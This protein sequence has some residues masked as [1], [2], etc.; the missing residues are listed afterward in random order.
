MVGASAVTTSMTGVAK[1]WSMP[2]LRRHQGP[3]GSA[4]SRPLQQP[5][6][7]SRTVHSPT[8]ER[9]VKETRTRAV[10]V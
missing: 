8:E 2:G 10:V 7:L 3:S 1:K 6:A 4:A 5:P 9:K